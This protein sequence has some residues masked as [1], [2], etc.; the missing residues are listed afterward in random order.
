MQLGHFVGNKIN[1]EE[2]VTLSGFGKLF[3]FYGTVDILIKRLANVDRFVDSSGHTASETP[4][5]T[6]DASTR[7]DGNGSNYS[8]MPMVLY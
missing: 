2:P 6:C 4:F 5:E 1:L 7:K 8:L 3:S